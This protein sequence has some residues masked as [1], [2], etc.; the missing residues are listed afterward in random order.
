[1]DKSPAE[2]YVDDEMS[3]IFWTVI[4]KH[5]TDEVVSFIRS[6]MIKAYNEGQAN[7]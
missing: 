1:M 7:S 4:L 2:L 5:L 3:S 6:E